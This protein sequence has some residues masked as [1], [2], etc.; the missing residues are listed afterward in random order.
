M[1][2]GVRVKRAKLCA[3]GSNVRLLGY[4]RQL[5]TFWINLDSSK[6]IVLIVAGLPGSNAA[7]NRQFSTGSFGAR[8]PW[9]TPPVSS[10]FSFNLCFDVKMSGVCAGTKWC[11]CFWVCL[12]FCA[13]TTRIRSRA[14]KDALQ[15][16]TFTVYIYNASHTQL[17]ITRT[18]IYVHK[19]MTDLLNKMIKSQ[20]ESQDL[21]RI[22]WICCSR[23]PLWW[24]S[25]LAAKEGHI[26]TSMI[27][28]HDLVRSQIS[29]ELG[30]RRW[31]ARNWYEYSVNTWKNYV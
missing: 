13:S 1:C 24:F 17:C 18:F 20:S 6:C 19:I 15:V 26:G 22:P 8:R 25:C 10:F 27:I 4:L 28:R 11:N 31:E 16:R 29:G 7:C 30:V 3:Y 14:G 5:S 12:R 2:T 21:G 23:C 9:K